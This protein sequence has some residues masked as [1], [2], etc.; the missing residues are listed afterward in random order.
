MPIHSPMGVRRFED[1]VAWQLTDQ[2]RRDVYAFAAREPACR[3]FKYRDQLQDAISSACRN[4]AEGFGRCHHREFRR[5]L[6]I[7]AVYFPTVKGRATAAWRF[8][9]SWNCAR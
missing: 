7:A 8:R 1:L 4:T 5:F 9:R 6:V 3:D 2:L